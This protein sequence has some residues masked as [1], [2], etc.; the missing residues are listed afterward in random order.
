MLRPA[1][2]PR[3]IILLGIAAH[4][5]RAGENM[6]ITAPTSIEPNAQVTIKWA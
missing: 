3:F 5:V 6:S 1:V 2:L 4:H